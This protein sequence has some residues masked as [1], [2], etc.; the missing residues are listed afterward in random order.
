M[1]KALQAEQSRAEMQLRIAHIEDECL[2]KEAEV[3]ELRRRITQ[4]L[5]E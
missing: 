3:D 1:R 5:E 2:A 4:R